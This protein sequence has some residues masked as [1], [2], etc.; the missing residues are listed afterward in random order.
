MR[1]RAEEVEH[2]VRRL[3]QDA[4]VWSLLRRLQQVRSEDLQPLSR[5]EHEV[6]EVRRGHRVVGDQAQSGLGNAPRVPHR[7]RPGTWGLPPLPGSGT[8]TVRGRMREL[9][10]RVP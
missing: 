8:G 10:A 5:Q 6:H 4:P 2:E 1:G 9:G 3:R 7:R